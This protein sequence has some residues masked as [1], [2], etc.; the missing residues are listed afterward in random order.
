MAPLAPALAAYRVRPTVSAVDTQPVPAITGN[1]TAD[2]GNRDV[3]Q[4]PA[5]RFVQR[6]EFA[7]GAADDDAVCAV[8]DQAVEMRG[9]GLVIETPISVEHRERGGENALPVQ[10]LRHGCHLHLQ[11]V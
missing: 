8:P 6:H 5:L 9:R 3:D 4:P 1:A 7:A 2:R 10:P 11:S